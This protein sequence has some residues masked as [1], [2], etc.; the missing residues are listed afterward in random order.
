MFKLTHVGG[1]YGDATSKYSVWLD[2]EYTI[3]EFIAAILK[4]LPKEWGYIGIDGVEVINGHHYR[5]TFG[6]PKCEYR[7]GKLVSSEFTEEDLKRK[8]RKVVRASGGWTR[9]DYLLEVE[10]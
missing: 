10:D 6:V 3:G 7:C 8:I 4:N 9:M 2:R 1:P 5:T